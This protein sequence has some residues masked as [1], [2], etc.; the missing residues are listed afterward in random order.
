MKGPLHKTSQE[1]YYLIVAYNFLA[2]STHGQFTY[3]ESRGNMNINKW[4]ATSNE[5][6]IPRKLLDM[7][8]TVMIR[9]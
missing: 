4:I 5:H 8:F 9:L 1:I 3:L 6:F 7:K 2:R